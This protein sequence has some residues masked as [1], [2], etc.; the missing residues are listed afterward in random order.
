MKLSRLDEI[1]KNNVG[2]STQKKT[3]EQILFVLQDIS[4]TLAMILDK[5]NGQNYTE[6]DMEPPPMLLQYEELADY[7]PMHFESVDLPEG[8]EVTFKG[9]ITLSSTAF[10]TGKQEIAHYA[11]F[12]AFGDDMKMPKSKYGK[13][14]RCWTREPSKEQRENAKWRK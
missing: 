3:D 1:T 7:N 5:M 14:W 8:Y 4:T 10:L 6:D 13:T 12:S 2:Y 11:L 9:E